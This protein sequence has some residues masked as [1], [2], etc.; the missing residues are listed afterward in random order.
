MMDQVKSRVR[1]G[2]RSAWCVLPSLVVVFFLFANVAL[3]AGGGK[4]ATK[5][6]NVADTR[7]LEPGLSLWLA[8]IYNSDYW[9]YGLTVVLIMACMGAILGLSFDWLI[10]LVGIK[11]DKLEH[12]E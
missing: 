5:L 2:L 3:A 7:G 9:L 10:G 4:P 12:H 1:C 6:V 11:F 8:D